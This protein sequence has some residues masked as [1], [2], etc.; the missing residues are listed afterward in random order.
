MPPAA[1]QRLD[2]NPTIHMQMSFSGSTIELMLGLPTLSIFDLIANDMRNSFQL[3]PDLTPYSAVEPKQSLVEVNP[4]A[5]L[6]NKSIRFANS[7]ASMA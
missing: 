1:Y 3:K 4:P 7:G 2:A 5:V 6:R